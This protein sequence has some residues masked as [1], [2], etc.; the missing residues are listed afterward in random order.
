MSFGSEG[1]FYTGCNTIGLTY[2][3]ELEYSN[4]LIIFFA[5]TFHALLR[6]TD[7]FIQCATTS[8]VLVT[9]WGQ[10]ES[11]LIGQ[12]YSCENKEQSVPCPVLYS[13]MRLDLPHIELLLSQ[14]AILVVLL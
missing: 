13:Q 10:I 9:N 5:C 1:Y 6:P 12:S 2:L 4:G 3:Q 14:K 8:V 11:C 7:D